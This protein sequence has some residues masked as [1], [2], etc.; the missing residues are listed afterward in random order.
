MKR[1]IPKILSVALALVLVLSFSLV[2]AV[3]VAAGGKILSVVPF[4][5]ESDDEN[6]D[7]VAEWSTDYYSSGSSSV[8]L[9]VP[10]GATGNAYAEFYFPV[11]IPLGEIDL[12]ETSYWCYSASGDY[13]PYLMFELAGGARINDDAPAKAGEGWQ[14]YD[15]SAEPDVWQGDDGT[16]RTWA[17]TVAFYHADTL[18][19]GILI[20]NSA[21]GVGPPF[22]ETRAYVDDITVNGTTYYDLIQDAVDAAQPND[23]ITVAA[24]TYAEEIT[25]DKNLIITCTSLC[26]I[27]GDVHFATSPITMTG[28]T[29]GNG[30][31]WYVDSEAASIQAAIDAASEGDTINVAAGTYEEDIEIPIGKDNLELAGA[32]GA[33]IKG[34]D[35]GAKFAN[36]D[37]MIKASGAKI[38]GFTI[39][40]PDPVSGENSG[41]MVIGT[42]NVEIYDNA[43]QVTSAS[44]QD[45]DASQA[46]QTW[47]EEHY[48]ILGLSVIDVDGLSIH[49][50]TF[51]GHG[52]G[53]DGYEGIYINTDGDVGAGSISIA[54]NVFTGDIF[55]AITV[56]RSDATISGNTI[57]TDLVP[58]VTWGTGSGVS[59]TGININDAQGVAQDAVT[60]TGN[61]IKGSGTG[62]G[63]REGIRI[64]RSGQD[65]TNISVT[66]N[67][68]QMNTLGIKIWNSGAAGVVVNY[69]DISGNVTYGVLNDDIT[70]T[71]DAKYNWWGDPSGPTVTT[72]ARGAGDTAT[73]NV[74]DYEPWLHT[75]QATVVADNTRYYAYNLVSLQQ[76]WNIWSTPIAMD[77]QANTWKEYRELGVDLGL[78][79]GSNAYYFNGLTQS[80]ANPGDSYELRPCDA[81]Y[82][83]MASA[84]E[85]PILFSPTVSAP[86]KMLYPGWNLVSASYFNDMNAPDLIPVAV[87]TALASVYYATGASNIG[88]S[89]VTSPAVNQAPW[90]VVRGTTIDTS[91]GPDM[92]P[93]EGYWVH[94]VNGGTL[95]GEVFTPVSPLLP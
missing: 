94:M 6:A 60:V 90:S 11:N 89:V 13:I 27:N 45:K 80:W 86:S 65:L 39:Q 28:A 37:I 58:G 71:L 49:D 92:V 12:I 83:K 5:L 40:G 84:Q 20:E 33:T 24:G 38:H 7:S 14:Q 68:V 73:V 67:T 77:E 30:H 43:F 88:Y 72:N 63:F 10:E 42:P 4:T 82:I 18:V 44:D 50:N 34:V 85:T 75:T 61:T 15:V 57:I 51:T 8:F 62:S 64:G 17:E 54:D 25:V 22:P 52:T 56:E 76:G 41:G 53:T 81:I 2:M 9:Y 66:N 69:N 79:S 23:T 29:L 19:T 26:T 91:L 95:V 3:P 87:E 46:I 35:I 55:R 47:A 36:F 21:I 1:K 78:A 32:S 93:T 16:F 31:E 74:V 70:G 48:E 59:W